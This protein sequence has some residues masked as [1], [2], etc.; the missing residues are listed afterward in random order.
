MIL[1]VAASIRCDTGDAAR[2]RRHS[3]EAAVSTK[4]QPASRPAKPPTYLLHARGR[5][6]GGMEMELGCW[7][8]QATALHSIQT[9]VHSADS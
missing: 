2:Y 9:A 6:G 3:G 5:L 4:L 8:R 7:L 1:A